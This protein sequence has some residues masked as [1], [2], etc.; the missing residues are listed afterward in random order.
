M[1]KDHQSH[2]RYQFESNKADWAVEYWLRE[3]G[4]KARDLERHPCADDMVT[5]LNI[6]QDLWHW[7]TQPERNTWGAYWGL[8]FRKRYPLN[9]KFWR[10]FE[11]IAQSIDHRQQRQ[12]QQRQ[13]IQQSRTLK[14]MDHDNEA[15]G[16]CPPKVNLQIN[17]NHGSAVESDLPWY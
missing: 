7:M 2:F 17:G 13:L 8:V 5:L 1:S 3:H 4:V 11:G 6:R 14:N 15:K 10:K 16:S 9:R 12:A